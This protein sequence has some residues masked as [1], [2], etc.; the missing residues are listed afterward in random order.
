VKKTVRG[1]FFVSVILSIFL[2]GSCQQV[3]TFSIASGLKRTTKVPSNLTSS[4]AQKLADE[5]LSSG[6]KTLANQLVGSYA[7]L[8]ANTTDPTEKAALEKQAVNLVIAGSGI[9][10][11]ISSALKDLPSDPANLTDAQKTQLQSNITAIASSIDTSNVAAAASYV[12]DLAKTDPSAATGSQMV[13]V[14]AAL[15]IQDT[16]GQISNASAVSQSTI[17]LFTSGNTMLQADGKSN[18]LATQIGDLMNLTGGT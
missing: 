6:D 2:L 13:M 1:G 5:A 9:S 4:Q 14:A 3:F 7:K 17:D 15:A 10:D 11:G 18:P 16:G 8:I 12:T